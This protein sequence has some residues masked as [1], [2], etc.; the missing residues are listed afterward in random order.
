MAAHAVIYEKLGATLDGRVI[1]E[2]DIGLLQVNIATSGSHSGERQQCQGHEYYQLFHW[3]TLSGTGLV[4][5][6]LL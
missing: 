5:S 3:V 1:T 2:I 4:L 6:I